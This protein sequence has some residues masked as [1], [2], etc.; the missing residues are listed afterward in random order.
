MSDVVIRRLTP[1]DVEQYRECRLEALQDSPTAFLSSYEEESQ[2]SLEE[3]SD[4]FPEQA[5]EHATFGAFDGERLVGL[6]GIYREPRIKRRHKANVVAVFV[7][8][9]YRGRGIGKQL[10]SAAIAFGRTIDGVERLE[11]SVEATNETAKAVYRSL[12]FVTWG[13]EPEFLLYDG[14]RYDEESMSLKL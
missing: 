9:E 7:R 3:L 1:E 6:T 12:G 2:R 10:V 14:K 8:P 4:R 13:V 11:L 5:P